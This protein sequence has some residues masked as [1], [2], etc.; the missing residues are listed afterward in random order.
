MI[1]FKCL[2]TQI[3]LIDSTPPMD[4]GNNIPHTNNTHPQHINSTPS[5]FK[6]ISYGQIYFR[7]VQNFVLVTKV[8]KECILLRFIIPH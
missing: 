5:K 1:N 3:V 2:N 4:R 6:K 7:N 8:P